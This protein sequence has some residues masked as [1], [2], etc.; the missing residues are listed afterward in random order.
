[1]HT[2]ASIPSNLNYRHHIRVLNHAL[3]WYFLFN[4]HNDEQQTVSGFR[5]YHFLY[6]FIIF[7]LTYTLINLIPCMNVRTQ[8]QDQDA[9]VLNIYS[10]LI[11]WWHKVI[12]VKS[13]HTFFLISLLILFF[14]RSC[15][16]SKILMATL[17]PVT[18]L[19]ASLTSEQFPLPKTLPISYL[20]IQR[21]VLVVVLVVVV[22]VLVLLL[23]SSLA[24]VF[25]SF[26]MSLS[27]S[28][29]HKG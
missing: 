1:M 14:L 24:I 28:F 15:S 4:L 12:E 17:S 22:L 18:M 10:L 7:T 8:N 23:P 11:K 25:F 29:L 16:L 2:E 27:F 19:R 9:E 21:V 13:E 3:Y 26:F 5:K 6:L 20:P